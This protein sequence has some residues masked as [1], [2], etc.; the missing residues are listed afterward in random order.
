MHTPTHTARTKKANCVHQH[1]KYLSISF[2]HFYWGNRLR[3]GRIWCDRKWTSKGCTRRKSISKVWIESSSDSSVQRLHW[4]ASFLAENFGSNGWARWRGEEN[5][6]FCHFSFTEHSTDS[7]WFIDQQRSWREREGKK[8]NLPDQ[9]WSIFTLAK[10]PLFRDYEFNSGRVK[11][12]NSLEIHSIHDSHSWARKTNS[13]SRANSE[14]FA[15][16]F[17]FVSKFFAA[18]FSF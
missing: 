6:E 8:R 7:S 13:I 10:H 12:I 2:T 5:H 1:W 11:W 15:S 14:S 9:R 3:V 17:S 4:I 16:D 18:N